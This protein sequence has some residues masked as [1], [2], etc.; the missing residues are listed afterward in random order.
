MI[1][2]TEQI[3]SK[4]DRMGIFLLYLCSAVGPLAEP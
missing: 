1:K 2:Q 4:Y 3:Q